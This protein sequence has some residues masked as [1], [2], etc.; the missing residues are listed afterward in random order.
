MLLLNHP[1]LSSDLIL[2]EL[3]K[4]SVSIVGVNALQVIQN[5]LKAIY[6]SRDYTTEDIFNDLK[7]NRFEDYPR[8]K[9][10][11]QQI[12]SNHSDFE[13]PSDL[14]DWH[15]EV[16]FH[17][18]N[19]QYEYFHEDLSLLFNRLS[20]ACHQ[21]THFIENQAFDAKM[22]YQLLVLFYDKHLNTEDNFKHISYAFSNFEK[23][24][25]D[26][27]L[28]NPYHDILVTNF[29]YLPHF[30]GL[31]NFSKWQA[32]IVANGV[33]ALPVFFQCQTI[34]DTPIDWEQAKDYLLSQKYPRAQENLNLA[35][36]CKKFVIGEQGF[37]AGLDFV[38]DVWPKKLHDNLPNLEVS[39][40]TQQ[41]FWLKLPPQ[42]L[43]ALYL[44]NLIPACC[45]FIH[46]ASRQ[47]VIDG[48]TLADNGF[49][50]LLKAK[51]PNTKSPRLINHEINDKE[52]QLVAH[53]YIWLSKNNN[54]CLDSIEFNNHLV[55]T[56]VIQ[57]LMKSFSREVFRNHP[58][59]KHIH[60]GSDGLTPKTLFH[61]TL[62]SETMRQ[63][64][65]YYD[66]I[67]QFRIAS[68]IPF[69][70]PKIFSDS[71][72][73]LTYI[74]PYLE[75]FE[76]FMSHLD[77]E[78][79]KR[80]SRKLPRFIALI[81]KP[82]RCEDFM[83]ISYEQFTNLSE[84]EKQ[85]ISSFR[86]LWSEYNIA[87][88]ETIPMHERLEAL[89]ILEH[90]NKKP[91]SI[92]IDK[93]LSLLPPDSQL[94]FLITPNLSKMTMAQIIFTRPD[95]F[96]K[97][98]ED[99]NPHRLFHFIKEF[100]LF[101][102]LSR[103]HFIYENIKKIFQKLNNQQARELLDSYR[104]KK[105]CLIR[106]F[107]HDHSTFECLLKAYHPAEQLALMKELNASDY[108]LLHELSGNTHSF[109]MLLNI[110]P[111]NERI[112]LLKI[113]N[114][115]GDT[116]LFSRMIS[117]ELIIA[118]LK[119]YPIDVRLEVL[120]EK[121]F[122]QKTIFNGFDMKNYAFLGSIINLL[123][124]KQID[125]FLAFFKNDF[126]NTLQGHEAEKYIIHF[127]NYQL[128]S[129]AVGSK[130]FFNLFELSAT[131]RQIR[132]L[133]QSRFA[134]YMQQNPKKF[135]TL[136]L[137]LQNSEQETLFNHFNWEGC[138]HLQQL[139]HACQM[140]PEARKIFTVDILQSTQLKTIPSVL[141]FLQFDLSRLGT[142]SPISFFAEQNAASNNS[143]LTRKF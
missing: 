116:I 19:A 83:P 49:Y 143:S 70:I 4:I 119:L 126:S 78:I 105:I 142:L 117:H 62:F 67:N 107:A 10:V 55:S 121:N 33:R 15:P 48:V 139:Y 81:P 115:F 123:L 82:L 102:N 96:Q 114:T 129:P 136:V 79:A 140:I 14:K 54:L 133:N 29:Y 76:E 65:Q 124:E 122:C 92:H 59:I 26:E 51:R 3:K 99:L 8:L 90:S 50:I 31:V 106:E 93:M 74:A 35:R 24:N 73:A 141:D 87:W 112:E 6:F 20:T 11:L 138:E 23:T 66:S 71:I 100:N 44:G 128:F 135:C 137:S 37:N 25:K 91:Y 61:S 132:L 109:G 53:S 43:R 89:K 41:Y 77:P 7:S 84:A 69:P 57:E 42:D 88:I 45:Q 63:G 103:D 16:S 120:M 58:D 27:E 130:V 32:F 5:K 39:D 127:L 75:N 21:M 108:P 18:I 94:E 104:A 12:F 131:V 80:I 47:C 86:K 36:I 85:N 111:E 68:Q 95:L 22:P 97:I 72:D 52:Y 30:S 28:A 134:E 40:S 101:S 13:I 64:E 118:I 46:G 98:I 125:T 9:Y 113:K 60:V 110:Y 38:Q 1:L 34:G 17:E 56:N 2:N